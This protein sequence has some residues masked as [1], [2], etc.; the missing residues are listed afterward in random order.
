MRP[1]ARVL[2]DAGW[3]VVNR[4][5]P[6][7]SATIETLSA[8]VAEGVAECRALVARDTQVDVVTHSMGGMLLRQWAADTQPNIGRAVMLGPP[9]RGSELVDRLGRTIAFRFYNGPAG[10]QQA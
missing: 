1:I 6:S 5:Y 4:G 2:R 7:R 3:Q 10:M 8:E 9:N